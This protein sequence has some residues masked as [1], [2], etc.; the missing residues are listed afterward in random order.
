MET[1]RHVQKKQSHRLTLAINTK[2]HGL[3]LTSSYPITEL[4]S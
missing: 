1:N 3:T 4:T 2:F